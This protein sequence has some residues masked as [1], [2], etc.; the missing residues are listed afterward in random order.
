MV[1]EGLALAL[2]SVGIDVVAR[3][4]TLA[5]G[6]A[7]I[8]QHRPDLVLLD[9]RLPDTDGVE[10]VRA[11]Q[12]AAPQTPVV[13]LTSVGDELTAADVLASGALGYVTKD[14]PVADLAR[15]IEVV[16]AGGTAIAPELVGPVMARLRSAASG[17]GLSLTDR[18]REALELLE[19]GKGISE[20]ATAL[21]VSRNTARK[22][23]QAILEKLG[24]HT[25]LEAVAIARRT[26]LISHT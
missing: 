22:H 12:H 26:G 23:V 4:G 2:E 9:F 21:G 16:R 20:V 6:V 15:A 13:V 10:G 3:A 17:P 18:E 25:Q 1:A 8:D 5:M 7:L 24:A 19:Q 11:I 14:V